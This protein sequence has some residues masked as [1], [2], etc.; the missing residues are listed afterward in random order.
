MNALVSILL[1]VYNGAQFLRIA[2]DSILKQTYLDFELIII[3][4]G[5]TDDTVA[6]IQA[7][8][9]TRVK[10][11]RNQVN[12]GIVAT[13]CRGLQECTGVYI[14]RM[15][16]DDIALPER[17]AEQVSFLEKNPHIDVVDSVQTVIDENGEKIGR[18]NSVVVEQSDIL[19]YLPKLNCLGHPSVMVR[20]HVLKS[21]GYRNVPYEDYDLWLRLAA[22]KKGI[23][24]LPTPLLL[25]REH[26]ASI[27]GTDSKMLRHFLKIIQTKRYYL[28]HLTFTET[29]IPFNLAVRFWLLRDISIHTSK[30]I[31]SRIK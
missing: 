15:D 11:F 30:R 26:S 5:S 13:L 3:D 23:Y 24:K 12:L 29:F 31:R 7:I 19:K 20:A 6:I 17:I 28:S 16:A 2:I 10:L 14:A 27:T 18:T 9:D 25:F 21:F 8:D 22:A 4:D 1:P